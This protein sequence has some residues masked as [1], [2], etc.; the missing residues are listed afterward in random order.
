MSDHQ[1][2]TA[3][4]TPAQHAYEAAKAASVEAREFFTQKETARLHSTTSRDEA[5]E[6]ALKTEPWLQKSKVGTKDKAINIVVRRL[7]QE[8]DT[9]K[10]LAAL[11]TAAS[12][13][14]RI[15]RRA[16]QAKEGV[17]FAR[18]QLLA[19]AANE[20]DAERTIERTAE[21]R[22]AAVKASRWDDVLDHARETAVGP[23]EALKDAIERAQ[24]DM[25]YS[26]NHRVMSRS[27]SLSANLVTDL[28][29]E[30]LVHWLDD[31]SDLL[32]G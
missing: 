7:W 12:T 29:T 9:Y 14:R 2:T 26:R 5:I 20:W 28:D 31:A 17:D 24:K 30:A 1:T 32:K 16:A 6:M 22:Q 21:L 8:T 18:K 25:L 4:P 19:V 3:I 13:E 11:E 23:V 10:A 15:S 27:T